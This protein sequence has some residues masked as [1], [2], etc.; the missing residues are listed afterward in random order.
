MNLSKL[1]CALER[2]TF[3]EH[4][5]TS[6]GPSVWKGLHRSIHS[7]FS[8]YMSSYF[9]QWTPNMLHER[10]HN[11]QWHMWGDWLDMTDYNR[12]MMHTK[13]WLTSNWHFR[14]Q[15][16]QDDPC[17]SCCITNLWLQPYYSHKLQLFV[18]VKLIFTQ[19][20]CFLAVIVWMQWQSQELNTIWNQSTEL[21]W[22][23]TNF[24]S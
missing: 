13:L 6:D 1:Q 24:I 23:P 12:L 16:V 14:L 19:R 18:N 4:V 20:F 21:T 7:F 15:L 17:C 5:I 3:L 2:F 22:K 9:C 10:L 11:Q 8:F